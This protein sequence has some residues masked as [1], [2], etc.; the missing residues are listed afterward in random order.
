M[1]PFHVERL[2]R[3]VAPQVLGVLVRR[4]GDFAAAEDVLQEALI[5]AAQQ[6]PEQGTPENPCGWLVHVAKRRMQD[7]QR[8]EL[9]RRRREE[10][11]VMQPEEQHAPAPD[12]AL[13]FEHDD[14]LKLLFM[15]CHPALTR[16]S[17]IALTLRAVGG[18][19]TQEIARAFLVPEATMAQ[20][21]SRAKQSIKQ[22]EVPFAL[23]GERKLRERLAAVMQ[24]L[25]LVFNE[26]Y[27]S[28][29]EQL[30]RVDLALEA[31]RLTRQL[32]QG[33]PEDSEVEGLLAL[34]LLT[35]AR[36]K[37]RVGALGEPIPLDEQDRTLWDAAQ[38]EE[39][40]RRIE[41]AMQRGPTG[42]YQIQAAIAALHDEAET[43]ETTDWTQISALYEAL[44][45][46]TQN[47]MVALN[48]A[49]ASAMVHGP[50]HGLELL[51]ALEARDPRVT[52]HLR[53][54]VARAHLLERQG[55][56]AAALS[57]YRAAASKTTSYPE[58]D[59]LLMRAARLEGD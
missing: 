2:L 54:H 41:A 36:R 23:P 1:N 56:V 8:A 31:I 12:S 30:L 44:Y 27:A 57:H 51:S 28:G 58:R 14:A 11:V 20:R 49:V 53:L 26:G 43:A 35:D 55:E 29:G 18:L 42:S 48:G 3:D 6:W 24:V 16:P 5:A 59:Y 38:I 52:D 34:M 9:A 7:I 21:I 39:G 25:Y 22:S 17:A 32:F 10:L 37:A 19:T 15:C 46:L 13:E 47:P 40:T 4:Y 45:R 33:F 50:A